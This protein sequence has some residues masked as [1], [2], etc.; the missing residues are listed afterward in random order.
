M[1]I[2]VRL[3]ETILSTLTAP[4]KV[5]RQV[6]QSEPFIA[7]IVVLCLSTFSSAVNELLICRAAAGYMASA[8]FVVWAFMLNLALSFLLVIGALVFLSF[9]LHILGARVYLGRLVWIVPLSLAPWM[10]ATPLGL[11][12]TCVGGGLGV[13]LTVPGYVILF[14]WSLGVLV[15]MVA[16]VSETDVLRALLAVAMSLGAAVLLM[17]GISVTAFFSS[18]SFL[19]AL[20]PPI[21]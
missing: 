7:T 2:K 10:L 16:E 20:T 19:V 6:R 18:F 15:Q 1:S 5:A 17:W 14:F 3:G 12:A 11:V 13:A 4:S 21:A 8:A 9:F